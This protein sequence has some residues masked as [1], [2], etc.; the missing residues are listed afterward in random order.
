MSQRRGGRDFRERLRPPLTL[1]KRRGGRVFSKGIKRG[2]YGVPAK[3]YFCGVK[4]PFKNF[5]PL[6]PYEGER[7]KG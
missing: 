1:L 3:I 5:S 4:N 6:S 2:E 7:D